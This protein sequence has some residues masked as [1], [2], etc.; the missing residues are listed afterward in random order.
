[1]DMRPLPLSAGDASLMTPFSVLMP[2]VLG[3]HIYPSVLPKPQ[4][5]PG[6][7]P[8]MYLLL[9]LLSANQHYCLQQWS[10]CPDCLS[11]GSLLIWLH[12]GAWAHSHLGTC[13]QGQPLLCHHHHG[14]GPITTTGS[15]KAKFWYNS[16]H[17]HSHLLE[18][19]RHLVILGCL[20]LK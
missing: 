20:A 14:T 6:G 12:L 17:C 3:P 5:W 8:C 7:L 15:N 18:K 4:M 2:R 19:V 16:H 11:F 9:L 1:M 13:C 10:N